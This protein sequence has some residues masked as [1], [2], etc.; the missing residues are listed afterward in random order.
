M[1]DRDIVVFDDRHFE[2]YDGLEARLAIKFLEVDEID[3]A[4]IFLMDHLVAIQGSFADLMRGSIDGD[5]TKLFNGN[6][7][8]FPIDV[9]AFFLH[10]SLHDGQ[11]GYIIIGLF[12]KFVHKHRGVIP[13]ISDP[14]VQA[15]VNFL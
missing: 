15:L 9:L 10:H 12:G 6:V 14:D 3:D 13:C 7:N 4:R 11:L 2:V 1:P 5:V 8:E